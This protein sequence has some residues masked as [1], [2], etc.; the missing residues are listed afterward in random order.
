MFCHED[1]KLQ[2]SIP[3]IHQ[4]LLDFFHNS[5]TTKMTHSIPNLRG[6]NR[7]IKDAMSSKVREL[8]PSDLWNRFADLNS[9]PRPS[10]HEEKVCAWIVEWA[11]EKA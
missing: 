10:K 3:Y 11:K 5:S 4:D 7:I 8:Q 6:L 2:N 9:I 1:D